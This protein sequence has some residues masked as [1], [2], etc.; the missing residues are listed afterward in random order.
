MS[1]TFGSL[2]PIFSGLTRDL[3]CG[4]SQMLRNPAFAAV[5]ILTLALGLGATTAVFSELYATVLRPL[6]YRAPEQLVV[7]HNQF[8]Q[9]LQRLPT[10]AFDYLDLREHHELFSDIGLYYFLDLN[11]TGVERPEKV[12]A[13]AVT[14]SLFRTLDVKPLIGRVFAPDEERYNGPHAVILSEQ[15]WRSAL[16]GDRQIL[17]RS[18][19]MNGEEYRIVGVMPGSFQ[20]PNDVTQMWTPVTLRPK[21]LASRADAGYY[22]RMVARLAP[23]LNVEQ[24]AARI[25]ELSRQ[26]ALQHDGSPRERVGWHLFLL[27]MARDDD[28][29]V[30][31]WMAMLFASVTGLLILVCANV[32]GLLL[33]RA[34]ERQFDF[35]VRMALGASRFRIARQ[36][37]AEVLLLAIAG[38]AAGLLIAQVALRALTRYG[39]P[40]ARPELNA[41]VFWFGAGLTLATGIACALYP[42]WTATRVAA[43]ES[44]N[45]AG[46]QRTAGAGKRRWQQ[47]LIV[48]QVGIATTLLVS[49]GLLL[50]SFLRL[51]ET[52]LGFNPRHVLT[53]EI[54][55]PPLRY[56]TPESHARFF[57]QVLDR[58]KR[59]PGV[60]AASACSLLPFGYGENVNTYEIV[61]RPKPRVNAYAEINNVWP[62]YLKTMEIPLLRGRFLTDRDMFA[63]HGA[64]VIDET[65]AKR[66]FGDE[67]PIGRYLKMPW[68]TYEIVGV[69]GSV[70]QSAVDVEAAPTVYFAYPSDPL[71]I[72]SSLP[73]GVLT[74]DVQQIVTQMDKD[75]PVHEVSMLETYVNHSLKTRRFVV[76]LVTL[77]GAA[78]TLLSAIGVYGLLSYSIAVRRRELGIRMAIGATGRAIAA[79]VCFGGIRL[80]IAGAALGCLGAFVAHRYI[81][82]QLYGV[83]FGDPIAWLAAGLGIVLAGVLACALPAWRAARMNPA[84]SLR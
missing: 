60:Q 81:A 50:R 34:T 4:V 5:M 59:I 80:V 47:A 70:K 1:S 25:G 41:P 40:A 35:A 33:V 78:G 17:R 45:E 61:G 72:R 30:R 74:N 21:E 26:M 55:L 27:P 15:Y 16:A 64:A 18:M 57:G 44:L 52:P 32:A 53:M 31:R 9:S 22:L 48:A 3:K 83:G 54:S 20:F 24:A 49:G 63:S 62:D 66:S 71:V 79:L 14:A 58:V 42:A 12:N 36:A 23:S 69:V 13:V 68:A 84:E 73:M 8:S 67:N 37:L 76:F 56:P 77:F 10:S 46:H 29:S 38:G 6:P 75:Q 11:H 19:Q 39:P 2:Q 51:L 28:G 65:L 7:V 82:S 43:I